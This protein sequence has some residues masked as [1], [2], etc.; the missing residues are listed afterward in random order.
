MHPK[1]LENMQA[2][3]KRRAHLLPRC[4]HC[5][6]NGAVICPPGNPEAGL[7]VQ[8]P[9]CKGRGYGTAPLE[10]NGPTIPNA[11]RRRPGRPR[12]PSNPRLDL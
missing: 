8:C 12:G 1:A 6:G 4:E 11:E 5:K 3:T 9:A 2:A 7:I 10:W